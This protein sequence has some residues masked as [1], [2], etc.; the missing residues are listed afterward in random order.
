[1]KVKYKEMLYEKEPQYLVL[2]DNG[3]IH[4]VLKVTEDMEGPNVKFFL[5][6]GKEIEHPA[7]NVVTQEVDRFIKFYI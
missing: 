7:I 3:N 4:R 1:M 5:F 2:H 6:G